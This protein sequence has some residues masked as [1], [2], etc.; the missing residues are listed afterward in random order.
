MAGLIAL[1]CTSV[2]NK[3]ATEVYIDWLFPIFCLPGTDYYKHLIN[4]TKI[5]F[6]AGLL[7]WITVYQIVQ[8]CL[9]NW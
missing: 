6:I 9:I 4:I 2:L 7:N 8:M 3:V 1:D 5:G